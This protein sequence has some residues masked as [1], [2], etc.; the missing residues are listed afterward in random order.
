MTLDESG[1]CCAE[2]VLARYFTE[3]GKRQWRPVKE[4]MCFAKIYS[5]QTRKA[6]IKEARKRLGVESQSFGGSYCWRWADERSPE[7][8]WAEKSRAIF[9]GIEDAGKR[10]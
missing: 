6:E 2:M 3:I 1:V 4:V 7:I 10:Y 9:G 5:P 8:V